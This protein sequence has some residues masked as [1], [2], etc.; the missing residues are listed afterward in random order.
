MYFMFYCFKC[1]E[2]T[3]EVVE[4]FCYLGDL[5]SSGGGCSESIVARVRTGWKKFRELLPLLATKGFSLH[6]KG[7]LY[8]GCV[9]SAMLHGSETWAV[10]AEDMRRLERSE[11]SM[12]RWMCSVSVHERRSISELRER[13]GIRGIRCSVQERRLRWY[14]HVMRMGDDRWVK[15][16][17]EIRVEGTLGRGR[18]RKTWAEV[19][20]ADLRTL[21]LT[22][23]MTGDRAE[24]RSAVL[25]RTRPTHASMEKRT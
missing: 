17:Q 12:L 3:L 4:R 19:A 1:Q 16:C 24:W 20:R 15:K 5:I 9:R 23:E 22:E 18:P 10:N 11:A 7:R 21:K 2:N 6:T 25:E 8:D 14:G 13:M